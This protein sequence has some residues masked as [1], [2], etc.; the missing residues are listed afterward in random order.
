MNYFSFAYTGRNGYLMVTANDESIT[1]ISLLSRQQLQWARTNMSIQQ[2]QNRGKPFLDILLAYLEGKTSRISSLPLRL[3]ALQGS[4]FS[5]SVWRNLLAIPRGEVTTYKQVAALVG[6][7]NKARAV[8][9][10]C[11]ANPVAIAIPCHRVV[12]ATGGLGGYRWGLE[13]KRRL[14]DI[15][16]V[17]LS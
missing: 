1:G 9:A 13:W 3:E 12:P 16:G 4:D 10:A 2:D 15:E 17:H 8:G 11:A 6:A 5:R 7:G 14:L